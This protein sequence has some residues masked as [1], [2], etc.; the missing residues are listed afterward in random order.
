[1]SEGEF[2]ATEYGRQVRW[3]AYEAL[4]EAEEAGG[5]AGAAARFPAGRG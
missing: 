2:F 4:R 3:L 1:M 5:A